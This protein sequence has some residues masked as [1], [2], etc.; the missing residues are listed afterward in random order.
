MFSLLLQNP[1]QTQ[2]E[3]DNILSFFEQAVEQDPNDA[4]A[5]IGAAMTYLLR[6]VEELSQ[7]YGFE[8]PLGTSEATI[9]SLSDA[10]ALVRG[11]KPA[12]CVED[13]VGACLFLRPSA[14]GVRQII[15][16]TEPPLNINELQQSVETVVIPALENAISALQVAE[17]ITDPIMVLTPP[18]GDS[19]TIT[20]ADAY[21]LECAA[22]LL[23]ALLYHLV[24]YSLDFGNFD[25]SVYDSPTAPDSDGNGM[26]TPAEYLPPDPFLTLRSDGATKMS[27]ALQALLRAISCARTALTSAPSTHWWYAERPQDPQK[28][29]YV[30]DKLNEAQ[31][32]LTGPTTQ[33]L[34]YRDSTGTERTVELQLNAPR[35]WNNP[36][37]DIKDLMPTFELSSEGR[38]VGV[39]WPDKTF[40]G[41]LVN[42]NE[43][44]PELFQPP[45]G[46][47]G[48]GS[49]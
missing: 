26:S 34:T 7:T 17:N 49:S 13:L 36:V 6:A 47:E 21:V 39:S 44:P 42:G 48:G 45:I 25:W 35:I 37:S 1:P 12:A 9:T 23:R 5:Q 33:T 18:E 3:L 16:G 43:L 11:A 24:A 31:E 40:N 20:S 10:V 19:I 29:Q 28:H 14:V 27:T 30:L 32:I 22:Q 2:A 4:G 46:G 15:P 8:L 38:I 41:V